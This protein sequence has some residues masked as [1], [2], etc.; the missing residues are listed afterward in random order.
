[1]QILIALSLALAAAAQGR[2]GHRYVTL[3]GRDTIAVEEARWDGAVLRGVILVQEPEI[4]RIEYALYASTPAGFDSVRILQFVADSGGWQERR[5]ATLRTIGDSVEMRIAPDGVLRRVLA[6]APLLSLPGSGALVWFAARAFDARGV[7]STSLPWIAP[8]GGPGGR[9][10]VRRSTGRDLEYRLSG[11]FSRVTRDE[12]G[13]IRSIDARATTL[14]VEVRAAEPGVLQETQ[15]RWSRM[16]GGALSPRDTVRA[17]VADAELLIDY[18]R[19]FVRGR[20]VFQAG[21]LGDSV[22]RTGANAATQLHTSRTLVFA[23]TPLAA[24]T[25]S[26]FTRITPERSELILNRRVGIWGTQYSSATDVLRVP[27][28]RRRADVVDQFTISVDGRAP[29]IVLRWADQEFRAEF[30][31]PPREP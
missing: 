13:S 22:W 27:M 10:I 15:E 28:T 8:L 12:S 5:E 25:Y 16:R 18:G 29:A 20:D 11:G 1:M 3:L 9:F 23:G 31:I 19:P 7:D 24:G 26:V 17:R 14:K 2:Q 6:P 4:T 21:V 30:T